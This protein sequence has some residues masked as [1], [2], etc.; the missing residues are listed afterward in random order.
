M[1]RV[2]IAKDKDHEWNRSYKTIADCRKKM[3]ETLARQLHEEAKVSEDIMKR[4]IVIFQAN[5]LHLSG[6][7][8]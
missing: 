1:C 8:L 5:K 7:K 3:Q 4:N 2:A 6:N